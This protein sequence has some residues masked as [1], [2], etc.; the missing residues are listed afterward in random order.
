MVN[1]GI[2]PLGC[3]STV[4]LNS[5]LPGA[6]R[7]RSVPDERC[8]SIRCYAENWQEFSPFF[9]SLFASLSLFFFGVEGVKPV[10]KPNTRFCQLCVG[11]F[12]SLSSSFLDMFI[13]SASLSFICLLLLL[14]ITKVIVIKLSSKMNK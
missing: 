11:I 7:V 13:P 5:S 2:D 10:C 3:D 12:S 6:R 4:N 14:I 8:F 9:R 1:G